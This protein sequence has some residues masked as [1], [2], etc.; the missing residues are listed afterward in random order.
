MDK[1]KVIEIVKRYKELVSSHLPVKNL[2][3]FGSY[4]KGGFTEES[5]IDV[6]VIVSPERDNWL[7]DAPLLWK[8]G[9]KVNLKIE[10]VLLYESEDSPLYQEIMKT[11][12]LIN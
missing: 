6:A 10:P 8:L 12:I 4:S 5:D 1:A 9:M 11:G 2:Y 7:E 3:L